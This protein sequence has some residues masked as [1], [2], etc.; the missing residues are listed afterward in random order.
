MRKI[1]SLLVFVMFATILSAQT[2]PAKNKYQYPL[3]PGY[4]VFMSHYGDSLMF[5]VDKTNSWNIYTDVPEINIPRLNIGSTINYADSVDTWLKPIV[6]F[7][8]SIPAYADSLNNYI[9]RS[10]VS[11]TPKSFRKN[12]YYTWN[13]SG[14]DSIVPINGHG[15]I[16][17]YDGAIYVYYAG[18]WRKQGIVYYITP[19]RLAVK[20]YY[21]FNDVGTRQLTVSSGQVVLC[22]SILGNEI[23]KLPAIGTSSVQAGYGMDFVFLPIEPIEDSSNT[24]TI[25]TSTG[26]AI[27]TIKAE[28]EW[29]HV[30]ATPDGWKHQLF[31]RA[32]SVA[33]PMTAKTN[34]VEPTDT[35]LGISSHTNYLIDGDTVMSALKW[36]DWD[37]DDYFYNFYLQRQYAGDVYGTYSP[38]IYIGLSAGASD[39]NSLTYNNLGIGV[40]ALH[41]IASGYNYNIGIGNKAGGET[42]AQHGINIGYRS[43][44]SAGGTYNNY[45]GYSAG[46]SSNNT[47]SI[48]IGDGALQAATGNTFAVAIGSEAGRDVTGEA[49]IM[50]G[51][52][53]GNTMGGDYNI[54]IGDS[55]GYE[56]K[57]D[58][59]IFIGSKAGFGNT[60]Y[61]NIILGRNATSG[62]NKSIVIGTGAG[63]NLG[64]GD[65]ILIGHGS[66]VNSNVE[67]STLIGDRVGRNAT[68]YDAIVIGD[69]S[70]SGGI[71]IQN[72]IIIGKYAMTGVASGRGRIA[73]GL[74]ALDSC[75]G[76]NSI[77][78]GEYA[79][80]KSSTSFGIGIGDRA[81]E[82]STG[83]GCIFIGNKAGNNNQRLRAIAIGHGDSTQ[84]AIWGQLPDAAGN[85]G[86]LQFNADAI[87]QG[88]SAFTPSDTAEISTT[89]KTLSALQMAYKTI[90]IQGDGGAVDTLKIADGTYDGQELLLKGEHDTY[91]VTLVDGQKFILSGGTNFPLGDNDT[92]YGYWD[93]LE[94]KWIEISRSDN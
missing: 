47:N 24:V 79:L 93:A 88:R 92:W 17:N 21:K 87:V 8:D 89:T 59:C 28:S 51:R 29:I 6:G 32:I 31:G 46:E 40:G 10:N 43:G 7:T 16:N 15:V 73:I 63:N 12:T 77:A 9:A 76:S 41:N 33:H 45:M 55:A 49:N 39:T 4:D 82:N 86:W 52:R 90:R 27:D 34:F 2:F 66:A 64:T 70:A 38:N 44:Y 50:I 1:L 5:W 65:N 57:S 48:G 54:A 13:G 74:A 23:F 91:T 83:H 84:V 3:A 72:D 69:R 11:G 42:Q 36:Y 19:N 78:I 61:N 60:G 80:S 35:T 18:A 94:S 20:G 71:G 85:N 37:T 56:N 75:T 53:A 25:Q 81:G 67:I 22:G 58:T 14:W 30:Y 68:I 26:T 62:G